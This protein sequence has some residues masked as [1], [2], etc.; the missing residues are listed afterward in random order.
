MNTSP[1]STVMESLLAFPSDTDT[2]PGMVSFPSSTTA[3]QQPVWEIDSDP[4]ELLSTW[5]VRAASINGG[6]KVSVSVN[7][8]LLST[9]LVAVVPAVKV[10]LAAVVAMETFLTVVG[11]VLPAPAGRRCRSWWCPGE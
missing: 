7:A 6:E 9:P 2:G 3:G 1:L 5:A 8:P 10:R 4:N 11:V